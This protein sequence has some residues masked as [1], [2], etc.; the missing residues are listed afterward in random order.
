MS[1]HLELRIGLE[2]TDNTNDK[3]N[4]DLYLMKI[5]VKIKQE[6]ARDSEE[7]L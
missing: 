6:K 3:F 2:G 4:F 7:I 5:N 1:P